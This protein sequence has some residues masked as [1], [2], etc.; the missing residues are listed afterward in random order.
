[1]HN[2]SYGA[3]FLFGTDAVR[4]NTF[5]LNLFPVII[6]FNSTVQMLF[7][8]GALQW[9]FQKLATVFIAFLEIS[10][11]EAIVAA[12]TVSLFKM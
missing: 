6:F 4:A 3:E 10:G 5:A 11:V 9:V 1:M 8:V 2:A 12:A 7:Y